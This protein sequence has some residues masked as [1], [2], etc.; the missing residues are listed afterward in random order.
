MKPRTP[1]IVARLTAAALASLPVAAARAQSL[2]AAP[3]APAAA[4]V[5]APSTVVNTPPVNV[6]LWIDKDSRDVAL[7]GCGEDAVQVSGM[8]AGAPAARIEIAKITRAEFTFDFDPS[9][10][11]RAVRRNDWPGAVRLL[12]PVLAPALPYLALPENNAAQPALQLGTYMMRAADRTL[13]DAKD[14]AD[15]EKAARQYTAAYD[16]F[17]Y[18]ARAQWCTV[19]QL[20]VLKGC[21]ALL[22]IKKPI[23]A[24]RY[25]KDMTEPMPGDAAYGHYWLVRGEIAYRAGR[26]RDAMDAV[27][28]SVCF[29]NKDVETFP[30]A[31]LLSAG[32]YEELMEPYR[33]RDVY[34]EVAKLF[35]RTDWAATAIAHLHAI[36]DRGLTKEKEVSPIENVFFKTGDD[37]NKLVDRLFKDLEKPPVEEE[38]DSTSSKPAP[39]MTD[40]TPETEPE[41]EP[42]PDR[43]P[44]ADASAV[45]PA[46]PAAAATHSTITPAATPASKTNKKQ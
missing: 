30:D 41:A 16:V 45:P 11:G 35:P 18:C 34:Y 17:R 43:R 21:R 33:A 5:A 8:A 44:P 20:G 12:Q 46:T 14:D 1:V 6:R 26:Y 10:L 2:S 29:E 39:K 27:L 40:P 28:K 38:E 9:D 37:I 31:L 13:R 4:P 15:R 7:A 32:C 24:E 42:P 22:A 36:M 3:A 19:G 25:V 23:T